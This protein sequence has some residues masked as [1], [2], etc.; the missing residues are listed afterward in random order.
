MPSFLKSLC[1]ALLLSPIFPAAVIAQSELACGVERCRN[2]SDC[3]EAA[4]ACKKPIGDPK[5]LPNERMRRADQNKIVRLFFATNRRIKHDPTLTDLPPIYFLFDP[6]TGD[7]VW[8]GWVDVTVPLR[9]PKGQPPSSSRVRAQAHSTYNFAL[10]NHEVLKSAAHFY[11]EFHQDKATKGRD[12]LSLYI[13][14]FRNTFDRAAKRAV[15]IA[16]DARYR[17]P[18]ILFSWPSEKNVPTPYDAP[19]GN[20]DLDYKNA[21]RERDSSVDDLA[22]VLRIVTHFD[23]RKTNIIAHSMGAQLALATLAKSRTSKERFPKIR[24]VILAAPDVA[25]QEYSSQ[26]EKL[27]QG[28]SPQTVIYCSPDDLLLPKV[29][30]GRLGECLPAARNRQ[31][32]E[33]VMVRRSDVP[34]RAGFF[35][36]WIWHSYFANSEPVLEDIDQVLNNTTPAHSRRHLILE[37]SRWRLKY[38]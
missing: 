24:T 2:V 1:A 3:D 29:P 5:K 20:I 36:A 14:G 22:T 6:Q 25:V 23:R 28:V 4:F 10:G 7:A 13:H 9:R 33:V 34:N 38:P 17:G 37:T 12:D 11:A 16:E 18:L 30:G 27:L 19:G 32:I 21:S 26:Y 8:L 35:E 31:S 15:Q